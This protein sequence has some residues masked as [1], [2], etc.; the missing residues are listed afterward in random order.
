MLLHDTLRGSDILTTQ[1]LPAHHSSLLTQ[2]GTLPLVSES[3][4]GEQV[5][6]A[7]DGAE[8]ADDDQEEDHCDSTQGD[9]DDVLRQSLLQTCTLAPLSDPGGVL[10]HFITII[11]QS[12]SY[13]PS[14]GCMQFHNNLS[15]QCL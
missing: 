4:A 14:K 8:E 3:V 13:K 2:Q 7:G 10:K 5:P 1:L 12:C 11:Y 15:S 6:E 9:D